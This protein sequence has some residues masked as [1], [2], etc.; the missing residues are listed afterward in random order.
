[1]GAT[2][3][4]AG[5]TAT[6]R[7]S[8]RYDP[9]VQVGVLGSLRVERDER[10]RRAAAAHG[11]SAADRARGDPPPRGHRRRAARR[12][13]GCDPAGHRPQDA[14]RRT[15]CGCARCSATDAIVTTRRRLPA[16]RGRGRRRRR[17]RARRRP[18]VVARRAVRRPRRLAVGRGASGPP[19]RA[20]P[21][22]R[23]RRRRVVA[24]RRPGDRRG[25]RARATR[26][27]RPGREVRWSL[28]VRAL[29]VSDRRPEALRAYE[30]ARRTLAAEL[31]ITPGAELDAAHRAALADDV[32]E[33]RD[34]GRRR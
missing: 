21:T 20:A 15:C 10:G 25:R 32:A 14:C 29:V 7:R 23:G 1:M 24:G 5:R 6:A 27:R 30:R 9:P 33:H 13:V 3:D 16:R 4:A 8:H 18:G 12:P 28:L 11:A 34:A 17:V 26:G 19:R 31:G 22:S 2:C